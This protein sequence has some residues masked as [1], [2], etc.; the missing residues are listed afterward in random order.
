MA[1]T[2]QTPLQLEDNRFDDAAES[3]PRH[4]ITKDVRDFL[5]DYSGLKLDQWKEKG[6]LVEPA[7]TLYGAADDD[8][9]HSELTVFTIGSRE[10]AGTARYWINT[11]NCMGVVRLRNK[12][13]G[14]AVQIEIGSRFDEG[15]KQFFLTYLLSKVFGGSIVDLVDLGRDSLW[16]MLLAFLFHR[17]LREASA[18]GLFKQYQTFDHNDTRVRG[19]IDVDEH[20]RRNIPFCGN[21]AYAT[22]EITFDN[23]TNHL[24]RHA[25]A[26]VGREWGGLLTGD[27]GLTEVRHQLE[28]NTPTWQPGKVM[29]CIRCKEN[30][31]PIKHPYFHAHYEPLREVSLAI[32][33]DEGAS[34]YQQQQEAEG[35][36]FDGSWLWEEYLWTLLKQLPGF[37]HPENKKR[38]G[39]WQTPPG[40][41]FYPDF[42]HKEKRVVLDA[43]YR[44]EKVSQDV[45]QEE[46]KQVLAYMFLLDAVHGGLIRPEKTDEDPQQ[47]ERRV[48]D[49]KRAN[50][51][52]F[53]LPPPPSAPTVKDFVDKMREEEKE[54][55]ARVRAQVLG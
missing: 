34:L 30:R 24:I 12:E 49:A 53:A 28:Q 27:S 41:T 10:T 42:F 50:W 9:A 15:R 25:L 38:A 52:N 6:V 31:T 2:S 18:V 45:R 19:R 13:S 46:A 11:H 1:Q 16:D 43:K 21:V 8:C 3:E 54:F 29:A 47:I 40:V 33:R 17:R 26:K 44:H 51:H 22:H 55:T 23:P 32:L 37:E 14:E 39:G 36:L 4:L 20:L 48:A 35:V 5:S 7:Q